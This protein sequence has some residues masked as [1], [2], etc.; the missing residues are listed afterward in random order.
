MIENEN[1]L[2]TGSDGGIGLALIN[3]LLE[4]GVHKIYATGLNMDRLH[5]IKELS[6][7]KI[8][9]IQLDITDKVQIKKCAEIAQDVSIL[10]NNAGIELKKSFLDEG[11]SEAGALEM[12]VN[13]FGM[14]DMIA[15]FLPILEQNKKAKIVN[16]LSM[17]SLVIVKRLATYCATKT[18]AHVLTESIRQELLEKNILVSGVYMGYVNT[19][20]VPEKVAYEKEEPINVAREI[21]ESLLLDEI[22]I[23]PD[24]ISKEYSE[25]NPIQTVFYQ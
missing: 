10:I 12:K 24:K 11:A 9:P 4:K 5:V 23:F 15:E 3:I 13:Y 22:H 8:V 17:A 16:I 7:N 21:I 2:I 6:P 18:A 1:V 19:K 25:K 20:M 14:I